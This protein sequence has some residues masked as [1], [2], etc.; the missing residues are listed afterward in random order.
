M[1][2]KKR[3]KG[4]VQRLH[5]LPAEHSTSPSSHPNDIMFTGSRSNDNALNPPICR[6]SYR[7]KKNKTTQLH[8]STFI[9]QIPP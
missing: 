7:R 6:A 2:V 9:P 4:K 5:R 8:Q 3:M 1:I